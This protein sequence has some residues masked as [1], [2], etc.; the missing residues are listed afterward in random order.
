MDKVWRG[1]R[2]AHWAEWRGM[3]KEGF[4][5]K[6]TLELAFRVGWEGLWAEGSANGKAKERET[7]SDT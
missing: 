5:E 3:F 4:K 7:W 2:R 1:T 6:V